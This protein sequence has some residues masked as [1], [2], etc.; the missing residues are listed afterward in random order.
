M[1]SSSLV[2]TFL[3]LWIALWII[4]FM[5]IPSRV[6]FIH[7]GTFGNFNDF[8]EKLVRFRL[9]IVLK[10]LFTSFGAVVLLSLAYLSLGSSIT[11]F[12]SRKYYEEEPSFSDW[13]ALAGTSFLLGHAIFSFVFI[14]FGANH[15]FQAKFVWGILIIGTLVGFPS[16]KKLYMRYLSSSK[17]DFH[18]L[19]GQVNHKTI[20][21]LT[22]SILLI[23]LFYSSTRLSYDAV[24]IYFS[25][26]KLTSLT[27]QIHFFQNDSFIAS[28]FQTGITYAAL[29]SLAGDQA[30]RM[31]SWVNG[32]III[33]F[34]LATAKELGLT[35]QA[36]LIAITLLLTSTA[37]VDLTGDGKID[38]IS[39]A[40]AIAAVYWTIVNSKG[41]NKSTALLTGVLAG[42]SI[43]SRPF[44][45]FIVCLFIGAYYTINLFSSKDK[46]ERL[47]ILKLVPWLGMGIVTVMISHLIVNQLVLGDPLSF[48][49]NIQIANSDNWQWTFDKD[50]LWIIRLLYPF[51]LTI[52]NIPQSNGNIS[53]LFVTFLPL[54]L[55]RT[56]RSKLKQMP[57]L[58]RVT[59]AA[60]ITLV[61]WITVLFT[62]FEIRYVLFLW[63]IFYIVLAVVIEEFISGTDRFSGKYAELAIVGILLF[64]NLRMAYI[65]I[66]TYSPVD[67]T[68][69][70]HCYNHDLCD[71]LAPINTIAKPNERVLTLSAFRYYLRPDLLACSSRYDEYR[72]LQPLANNNPSQFWAE[73]YRLGFK[74]ITFEPR[75]SKVHLGFNITPKTDDILD[76]LELRPLYTQKAGYASYEI[77][78]NN[79]PISI[80]RVCKNNSKGW[81]LQTIR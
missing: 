18:H 49:H 52:I 47:A 60:V 8:P 77:I 46:T 43:A 79:P 72:E 68:N 36:R 13:L 14:L 7:G 45:A 41:Q 50:K 21:T 35:I 16:L 69:T 9:A 34:F 44:N 6:D 74:Y 81:E 30:A 54:L 1:R 48:L 19:W 26:E 55:S 51:A 61:L 53:P 65:T 28:S 33:L 59:F 15:L 71:L 17:T 3:F 70:P 63:V 24:A 57:Q 4:A 64:A 20:F 76:W 31:Y 62:V 73:V 40:P 58:I 56:V 78:A 42:I 12:F 75:Y 38:L 5:F 22:I 11:R 39:T 32:L 25:D 80:D 27:N 23:G 37:F 66:D 10:D 2:R 67:K 29:I